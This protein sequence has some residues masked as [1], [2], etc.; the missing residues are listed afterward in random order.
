LRQ[1]ATYRPGGSSCSTGRA[2]NVPDRTGIEEVWPWRT[3]RPRGDILDLA[4]MRE[5]FLKFQ[6]EVVFHAAAH[7][8]VPMMEL[9]PCEAIQNNSIG[10]RNWQLA[11]EFD[12]ERFTLIPRTRRSTPRV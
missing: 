9:Q 2:P 4:R 3:I 5:I 10:M 1:I 6:P 11:L 12:V 8:H 7:K